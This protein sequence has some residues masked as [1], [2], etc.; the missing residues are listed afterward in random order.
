LDGLRVLDLTQ[1]LAGPYC[2]MLL[3]DLGADVIK[4]ESLAGDDTR[5]WVPPTR[6]G[7]STY[8]LAIN[9]NKRSVALNLSDQADNIA[10]REL[11]R[12]A[13]ILVENFKPGGLRRFG[14][15]YD[16]VSAGNPAVIY[17]SI[18]GF[19]SGAGAALPG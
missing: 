18:S 8:Y 11:A 3:A 2:T 14:L 13:D 1:N 4:V 19:G 16:V 6:G 7:V 9:R 12:R 10:A 5:T 15:G 17:A